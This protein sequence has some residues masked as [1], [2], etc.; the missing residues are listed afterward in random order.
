MSARP[1]EILVV[2]DSPG[3][4]RLTVEALREAELENHL[5]VVEDGEGALDFLY[6]RAPYSD[7]P[8]PDLIL[9]DLNLP[10]RNGREVLDVIKHDPSLSSIPVVV[11]STSHA[12]SDV[13][14]C[15]HLHANC[16][17]VKPVEYAEFLGMIRGLEQF[18]LHVATLPVH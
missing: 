16:Y 1:V 14:H 9:L 18:W 15:Y 11:L 3:A 7:V 2:E 17:I 12:E 4:V 6:R 5:S 10:R 13:N 8:R